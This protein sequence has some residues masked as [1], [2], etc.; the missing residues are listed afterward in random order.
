MDAIYSNIIFSCHFPLLV[1]KQYYMTAKVMEP[2]MGEGGYSNKDK[3]RKQTKTKEQKQ[4]KQKQY[5]LN[6][7]FFL[8]YM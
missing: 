8:N 4:E 1:S 5:K 2:R 3:E 6:I 7:F